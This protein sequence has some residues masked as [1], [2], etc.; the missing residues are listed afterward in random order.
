VELTKCI[1]TISTSPYSAGNFNTKLFIS[2][3]P[4]TMSKAYLN[5]R[6]SAYTGG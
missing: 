6:I 1:V 2:A 5:L 4:E 3:L